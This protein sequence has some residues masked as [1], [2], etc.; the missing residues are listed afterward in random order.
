MKRR[1]LTT[2]A[3]TVLIAGLITGCSATMPPAMY[4]TRHD[5][6]QPTLDSFPHCRFYGC[7]NV[8][9]VQL[10]AAEWQALSKHFPAR[11]AND[12]RER[13]AEAVGHFERIVGAITGTD[14]DV[15]GTYIKG[16]MFQ[17]DCVDESVNTT[18][19][20]MLM[21]QKG[22]LKFHAPQAPNSRPPLFSGRLGPHR[23]GVVMDK[24]TGIRYAVDSWFHDNG[25]KAEIVEL[26]TWKHGWHPPK[27]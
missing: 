27:E 8:D 16:G 3:F 2:L 14:E 26:A 4:Y 17:H 22:W 7:R 12:E 25:E 23:T 21:D 9:R 6:P 24:E 13:I 1:I 15:R 10:T 19:Y 5:M 11:D 20:L 18:T